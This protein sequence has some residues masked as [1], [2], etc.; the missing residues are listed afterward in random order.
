MQWSNFLGQVDRVTIHIDEETD[1]QGTGASPGVQSG[2]SREFWGL[3]RGLLLLNVLA[4]DIQWS[5][6]A[7]RREVGRGPKHA[8]PLEPRMEV[9]ELLPQQSAR[10]ALERCDERR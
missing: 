1:D 6:A 7:R 5:P 8:P 3:V 4:Q 9:P 10:H 2:V